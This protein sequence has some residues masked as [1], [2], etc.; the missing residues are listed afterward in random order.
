MATT[1]K[2]TMRT[3]GLIFGAGATLN[4]AFYFLSSL[5]FGS[6]SD[7]VLEHSGLI[8]ARLAFLLLSVIV[9]VLAFIASL[10]PRWIG[11]GIAVAMSIAALVGG[12]EAISHDMPAVMG[13]TLLV[14]AAIT[15][16]L[17]WRSWKYSRA[18]WSF[19]ISLLAVFA[20]VDFFG[21]PKVRGLLG[22]GL[23]TAM[24]LPALQVVGVISLA[25]LRDEYRA[26]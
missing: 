11:H 10:A 17:V 6:S 26:Q 3:A 4:S 1:R 24:I 13:A 19:L 23:W 5:Y 21:A 9:V 20:A 16:L 12:I 18:A 8:E 14:T 22:I 2:E 25:M 15:P 7:K